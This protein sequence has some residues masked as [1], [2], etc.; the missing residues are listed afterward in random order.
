MRTPKPKI[1]EEMAK[2]IFKEFL[3][4]RNSE[5][6]INEISYYSWMY[7]RRGSYNRLLFINEIQ[8]LMDDRGLEIS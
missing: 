6:F 4:H 3:K 7:G 2:K 1:T 5:K 8:S